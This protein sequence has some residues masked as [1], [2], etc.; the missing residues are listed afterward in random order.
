[1]NCPECREKMAI[2]RDRHHY[3]E[4]GLDNVWIENCRFLACKSGHGRAV[5][6]PDAVHANRLIAEILISQEDR[7]G[8][9]EIRFLR[10]AMRLTAE[11]L[12]DLIG[13]TRI[14]I[15][16]WENSKTGMDPYH[17]FRLR[18]QVIDKLLPAEQR[19]N[20]RNAVAATFGYRDMGKVKPSVDPIH[21]KAEQLV[22]A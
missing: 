15:S 13:V 17:E 20:A 14:E 8:A 2:T 9:D 4:S 7:L 6:L 11:A 19:S 1:M 10:K 12:A 22:P 18:M 5:V 21:V 16:R 3:V